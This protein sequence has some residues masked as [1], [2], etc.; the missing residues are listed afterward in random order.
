MDVLRAGGLYPLY[1]NVQNRAL[2]AN[3]PI[4]A[5]FVIKFSP[6]EVIFVSTAH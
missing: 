1:P 2:D 6:G 4:G 5:D 3:A